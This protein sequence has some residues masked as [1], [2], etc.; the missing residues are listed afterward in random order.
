MAVEWW[1]GSGSGSGSGSEVGSE[2]RNF[3]RAALTLDLKRSLRL[4]EDAGIEEFVFEEIFVMCTVVVVAGG[5]DMACG[6]CGIGC[7]CCGGS[8]ASTL[9]ASSS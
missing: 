5:E 8:V 1:T 9:D 6:V 2:R 3:A 7:S 4:V